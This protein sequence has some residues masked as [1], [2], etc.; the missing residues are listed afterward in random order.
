VR[1]R[2]VECSAQR[3]EAASQ[4]R[5]RAGSAGRVRAALLGL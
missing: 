4:P 2:G 5:A 1:R 3:R